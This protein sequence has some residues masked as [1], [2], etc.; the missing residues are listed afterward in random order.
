MSCYRPA[1]LLGLYLHR[2]LWGGRK[3]DLLKIQRKHA[4]KVFQKCRSM[5][6]TQELE[7]SLA[8]IYWHTVMT[9][10]NRISW[11]SSGNVRTECHS[12][13]LQGF[14]H[15]Q[16][17]AFPNIYH[18]RRCLNIVRDFTEKNS[19]IRRT[20]NKCYQPIEA[21][22]GMLSPSAVHSGMC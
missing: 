22:T 13:C 21:F 17:S 10:H 6:I 1:D 14:I 4:T 5:L 20:K 8:D 7:F 2:I 15:L 18:I 12:S 11:W 19:I 9:R 16:A 3:N